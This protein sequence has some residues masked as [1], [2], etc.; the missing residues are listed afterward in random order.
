ML[1]SAC[2]P[3]ETERL[4]VEAEATGHSMALDLL[5]PEG[6]AT[7]D[8]P[9]VWVI[10]GYYHF[11]AL[12]RH[13]ARRTRSGDLEP[14]VLVGVGYEDLPPDS[15]ANLMEIVT[16]REA[17]LT[18]PE[19]TRDGAPVGGGGE[20][21]REALVSELM[22]AVDERLDGAGGERVLM[23]HSLG[24][25]FALS[26]ALVFGPDD[27]PFDVIVAASPSIWWAEGDLLVS[28][29]LL[30]QGRDDLNLSLMMGVGSLEGPTMIEPVAILEE[31]LTAR[32][33]PSLEVD[34]TLV[35][36]AHMQAAELV[37]EASLQELYP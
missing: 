37:F 19:V 6:G 8:T 29:R 2:A 16:R 1:L 31:Q 28:E 20:R 10:D 12:A 5:V 22:P 35:P 32:G 27:S 18:W 7:E 24:G 13:V 9:V 23:G 4:V 21:F 17:D 3:P 15:M 14:L 33:Y 30:A 36:S 11:D 34:T 25:L 26:E